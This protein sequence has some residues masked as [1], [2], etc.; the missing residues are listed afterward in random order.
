MT[1]DSDGIALTGL[2]TEA[3]NPRTTDLDLLTTRELLARINQEDARVPDAVAAALPVL[4]EVVEEG[5]ACLGRGARIHYFGAGTSGRIAALDAAELPP[6]FSLEP[7]RV[8]AH[9]AG[10][11]TALTSAIEGAEDRV[12]DGEAA[13]AVLRPGDLALG[14]AASGRTPY[15]SGVLQAARRNGAATA[16]ISA[17]P[18]APLAPLADWHVAADTGPEAVAGSTRLKAGTAQKLL[19]NTFSTA[20]MVRL[21][22]TYSNLMVDL[23]ASNEK[24]RRRTLTILGEASGAD[25]ATCRATLEA[26]GGSLKVALVMLLAGVASAPATRA[27]EEASGKVRGAL[28]ALGV[29]R[30]T[31]A[32]G[33]DGGRG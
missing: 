7:D 27:L 29:G 6:T 1:E 15:V 22:K 14:L 20:V 13:A 24:L 19:L 9:Q 30:A 12:E 32:G 23:S 31:S 25:E 21:G 16:L 28:D 3:R 8:V 33:Q 17:N 4:A 26:A 11:A 2:P 10:G 18:T 5:V